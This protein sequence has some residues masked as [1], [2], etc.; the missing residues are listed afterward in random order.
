MFLLNFKFLTKNHILDI[1]MFY[2]SKLLLSAKFIICDGGWKYE[3][4]G[5]CIKSAGIAGEKRILGTPNYHS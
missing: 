3:N 1:L 5:I 4:L 2:K